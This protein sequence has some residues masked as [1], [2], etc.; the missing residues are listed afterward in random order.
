[1]AGERAECPP[2]HGGTSILWSKVDG[3]LLKCHQKMAAYGFKSTVFDE[4][5]CETIAKVSR[6]DHP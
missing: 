3:Y 4:E 2:W 6:L 5:A 1:V